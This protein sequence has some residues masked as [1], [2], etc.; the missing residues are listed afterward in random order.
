MLKHNVGS[1]L[2]EDSQREIV[3]IVTK[4]DILRQ[5]IAGKNLKTTQAGDIMS[6]PVASCNRTDTLEEALRKF[7]NYSRLVVK[8]ED[9]KVVGV[10]KKKIV[11][12]FANVSLAYDFIQRRLRK[13]GD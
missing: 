10:A 7:G 5:M 12:R 8:A 13:P 1:V 4:N 6:Y 3:G 11:E 2:V 9:G